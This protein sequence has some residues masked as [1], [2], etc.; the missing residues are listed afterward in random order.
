MGGSGGGIAYNRQRFDR[1]VQFGARSVAGALDPRRGERA[2]LERVRARG[3]A[4]PQG[5]RGD[6][7]L[8]REPRSDGRAHRRLDHGRA[9]DDADRQRVPAHA[10][11]LDRDPARDRRHDRRLER[12]VRGRSEDRPHARD[13]DE[14][15]RVAQLGARVEGDRVSDR[16]DRREARDRLH[17]RRAE[18]RHHARHAGV[19]RA[20]DRL[21]GREVA[22]VRVREVPVGEA[23]A[24]PADEVGR[25][26]DGDRPHVPRG[27]RQGDPLARD[28]ARRVRPADDRARR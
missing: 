10:R 23:G 2:R 13:R 3:R 22:A 9:G 25:R 17:A 1:M 5:Q 11:R 12:A 21:R 28:R 15:A 6:R 24:R 16:E 26:G 20:D 27:A 18:E 19:V 14:P 7:V 4:R 8:D